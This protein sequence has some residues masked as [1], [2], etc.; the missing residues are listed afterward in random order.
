MGITEAGLR[1]VMLDS[2]REEDNRALDRA[3]KRM[4]EKM[5]TFVIAQRDLDEASKQVRTLRLRIADTTH[6]MDRLVQR[7]E[8]CLTF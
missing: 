2:L 5:L 3:I 4:E 1:L 8:A 7:R 6:Q